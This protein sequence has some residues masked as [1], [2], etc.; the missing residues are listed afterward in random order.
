[1]E[2]TNKEEKEDERQGEASTSDQPKTGGM[3]PFFTSKV[4]AK[5]GMK[6]WLDNTPAGRAPLL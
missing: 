1:M 5:H 2:T 3:D 6:G 4:K